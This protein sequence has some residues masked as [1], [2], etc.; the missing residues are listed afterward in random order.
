MITGLVELHVHTSPDVRERSCDDLGLAR[1]AKRIGAR[2]VTIKSHH[3]LTADRA[4]VAR[5]AVPGVAVFGGVTL[6]P[7]VGGLNPAAVEVALKLGGKIVWLPT[8]FAAQHRRMEG[9]ADGITVVRDGRV[10]PAALEVIRQVAAANVILATGHQSAEEVPVIVAAAWAEGVRKIV[11]N[12]PEHAVV[13]MT[14]AQQQALRREY[15]VFFERCYAQPGARKGEYVS[16]AETN[17]R[18]I[19]AVGV[20]STVL[21]TDAGQVENP[22][23]AECWERIF[24]YHSRHGVAEADLRRMAADTPAALLGL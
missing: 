2:A 14:I 20:E 9:K 15:P 6:N 24:E 1:E 7:S 5:S 8:L 4:L 10:V 11:I 23:W 18:A 13:G 16:N 22:P 19:E 17:L 21:A 3:M 12:H